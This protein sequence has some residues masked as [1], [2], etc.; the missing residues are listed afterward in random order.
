MVYTIKLINDSD[1]VIRQNN[2]YVSFL[3]KTGEMGFKENEYKVEA[4]GNKLNI[5]P[6]EEVNVEVYMPFKGLGGL[7]LYGIESSHIKINGYL[8]CIDNEHRFSIGG[9]LIRE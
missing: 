6:G 7:S 9:G 4:D 8:N 1:F 2:V 3:I 5:Q